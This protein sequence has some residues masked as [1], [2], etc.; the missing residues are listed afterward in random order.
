[1]PNLKSLLLGTALLAATS[2]SALAAPITGIISLDGVVSRNGTQLSFQ[3]PV[4][5][6]VDGSTNVLSTVFD[7]CDDCAVFTTPFTYSPVVQTGLVWTFT[8]GGNT[9]TFTLDAGA[10]S[11]IG[12]NSVAIEGTGVLS[13]TNYDDTAASFF[14]TTQGPSGAL[15]TF[16]ST[17]VATPVPEPATLALFGAGLL[18]LA[19]TR[20]GRRQA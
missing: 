5:V 6:F 8:Q 11:A 17:S 18:G 2:L 3:N 13:L 12:A 15:V 10:T 20:R 7:P 19:A 1:M 14:F 9:L 4:D 16:S